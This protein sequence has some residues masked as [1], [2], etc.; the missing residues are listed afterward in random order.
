MR[1]KRK[2]KIA[3]RKLLT[4]KL[5]K[6]YSVKL[7][8]SSFTEASEL[9]AINIYTLD[10]TVDRFDAAPKSYKR[11]LAMTIECINSQDSD[12]KLDECLE[13]MG[14]DVETA[15]EADET[16]GELVNKLELVRTAYKL[17]PEAE[18][19]TGSLIL[20]YN[21]EFFTQP[22]SLIAVDDLENIEFEWKLGQDRGPPDLEG[23]GFID[24]IEFAE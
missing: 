7:S 23:E 16:L 2:I 3:V 17:E 8:R 24:E 12:E 13:E 11:I 19:A 1:L 20:T 22:S 9:P 15:M 18:I 10:E 14:A 21:I 5:G 6:K 4:E